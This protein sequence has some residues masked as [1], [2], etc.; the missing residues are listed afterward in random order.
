MLENE[1]SFENESS[2]FLQWVTP[3]T[4]GQKSFNLP[5]KLGLT[6]RS[7]NYFWLVTLKVVWIFKPPLNIASLT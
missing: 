2:C 5:K 3:Q 1:S 4:E 7:I 6:P